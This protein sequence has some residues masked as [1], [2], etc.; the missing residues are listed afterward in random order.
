[1]SNAS[2]LFMEDS[3]SG[4]NLKIFLC[5]HDALLASFLHNMESIG[6]IRVKEEGWT[7]FSKNWQGSSEGFPETKPE[8]NPKE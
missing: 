4:A 2:G 5:H 6:L 3:N 1:M 8:G 7:G